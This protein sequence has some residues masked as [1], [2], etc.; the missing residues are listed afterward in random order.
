MSTGNGF[1][2][3]VESGLLVPSAVARQRQAWPEGS[4]RLLDRTAKLLARNGLDFTL[5]CQN[6]KC[7][8][9]KLE[10]I[11]QPDGGYLLRCSCTDRVFVR[12][13]Y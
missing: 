2:P 11:D 7:L 4:R 12:S 10:R 9:T 5:E 8:A 6:P 13:A 1:E 3:H